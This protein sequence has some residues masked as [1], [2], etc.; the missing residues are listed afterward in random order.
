MDAGWL[1]QCDTS[2]S[3]QRNALARPEVYKLREIAI[4]GEGTWRLEHLLLDVN[5]TVSN[6]GVLIPGVV[7]RLARLAVA[8]RVHLLTADTFGTA[9]ELA[10]E[11]G[12]EVQM[13]GSGSDKA[14]VVEALGADATAAIGNG[15]NDVGM[16]RAARLGVAVSVPRVPRARRSPPPSTCCSMNACSSRRCG[17]RATATTRLGPSRSPGPQALAPGRTFVTDARWRRSRRRFAGARPESLGVFLGVGGLRRRTAT[18][19]VIAVR[20]ACA[21][22]LPTARVSKPS[23]SAWRT[24]AEGCVRSTRTTSRARSSSMWLRARAAAAAGYGSGDRVAS[25]RRSMA[26]WTLRRPSNSAAIIAVAVSG[27][28]SAQASCSS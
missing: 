4:P 1:P 21:R 24:M 27:W 22:A 8:L 19:C 17:C 3:I 20:A 11:L 2:C 7:D 12:A 18:R 23:A 13:I 6:R 10:R 15:R 28:S 26:A 5:G 9:R 25:I 16:L 14:A